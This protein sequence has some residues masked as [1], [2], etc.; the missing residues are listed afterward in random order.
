MRCTPAMLL[1]T[2]LL[3]MV[4]ASPVLTEELHGRVVGI[5]D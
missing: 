3:L 5:T 1:R 4:L 2:L